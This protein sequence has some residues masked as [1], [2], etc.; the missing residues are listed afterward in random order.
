[1]EKAKLIVRETKKKKIIAE[2]LFINTN[3][4][5]PFP[6]IKLDNVTMNEN[7]VEVERHKGKI[8]KVVADGKTIYSALTSQQENPYLRTERKNHSNKTV[9]NGNKFY[10]N[11][12]SFKVGEGTAG[13]LHADHV[14]IVKYA[15]HAPYN[16]IPLNQQV[17]GIKDNAIPDFDIYDKKRNTGWIE[18]EMETI[19][20]L[21]IKDGKE[22]K[23]T[24]IFFSPKG[25]P[26]IP[27]STLR[28]MTRN[29]VEILSFGKFINFDDKRLYFR[30]LA[31]QSNL[32]KEYQQKMATF[33]RKSKKSK[34]KFHAG[35]LRKKGLNYVIISSGNNYKQIL[36]RDAQKQ[37]KNLEQSYAEFNF[38]LLPGQGYLVVSG[39]MNNKKRDW[40]IE[41]PGNNAP[42]IQIS[43][44]DV[45]NYNNDITRAD[46][47][48]DLIKLA[49]KGDV[50]CFYVQWTDPKDK[51]RVSFGHTGMFRLAYEKSIGE[52]VPENLK[53]SK[54][55]DFPEAIFG[56]KTT[57]AS[58]VFF[59]NLM[60]C[61]GQQDIFMG[62]G[63]PKIMSS[64]KP[65]TFQHYLV[66]TSDNNRA[67]NHYNLNASIRGYKQ[68][69]HK[70]G[71]NW[72]EK[73]KESIEKHT[74]Q[75]TKINPV[76]PGIKF[77]GRIRFENLSDEELG[78]LL[79]ALDLPEGCFHKL[80][81]GKP[82]GLG[83]IKITPSLYISD[84]KNQYKSLFN[85]TDIEKSDI[86]EIKVKFEKY[87]LENI[88][89]K[90]I[91]NLWEVDRIKQLK[92]MLDFNTGKKLERQNDYMNITP[93][94]EFKNR[95][96]LPLPTKA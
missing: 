34:G 4:K 46:A 94:N 95:P 47:V 54:K 48:P 52:L 27:G 85:N 84:K 92:T 40:L 30:G 75:Y 19:T 79:F 22:S 63:V 33:D 65:T 3:K 74:S 89:D 82:L 15:A 78:A 21:F 55:I 70:S 8:I 25:K 57:F 50:P 93:V 53:E 29:L 32:R 20:P 24:A 71:E 28:G 18:I 68:Y 38:Y 42:E 66:Q 77:S 61:K 41:F 7:E 45:K 86:S 37:V 91:E 11:S 80:G 2:L 35:I 43:R 69:W 58:R 59:E 36:K 10:K 81:M 17:V 44:E 62:E 14:K 6:Q 96:I 88:E 60:L 13:L 26:Q 64:P 51:D 67:L 9:Q 90:K 83:S 76:K 31:D 39:D 56:N 5:M 1:M 87:I 73:D 72:I 49:A 16:F 12:T 23:E